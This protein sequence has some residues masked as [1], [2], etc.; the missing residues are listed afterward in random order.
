[1]SKNINGFKRTYCNVAWMR[2]FFRLL[3]QLQMVLGQSV[4]CLGWSCIPWEKRKK[5]YFFQCMCSRVREGTGKTCFPVVLDAT[6]LCKYTD[7][8]VV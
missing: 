4:L 5:V 3:L 8:D 1:M 2:N 6:I 7:T